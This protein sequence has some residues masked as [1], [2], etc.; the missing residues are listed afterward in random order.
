SVV[1]LVFAVVITPEL[2][3]PDRR[4]RVLTLYFSTAVSRSEYVLGKIIA[5]VL[6]L[7][8]LTLLPLAF[9]YAGNVVFAVHP[10]GY[11]QQH[12]GD[13]L[14]ILAG[15]IVPAVYFAIVGLAVASLTSRRAFAVGGFLALM[16]VPTLVAG[17][18]SDSVQNGHYLRLLALPVS[19]LKVVQGL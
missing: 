9:L 4:D 5:A 3:C 13:I 8:C 17:A 7:L 6:P 18:L 2:L 11:V 16:V 1:I 14:R 19:P 15:G 12:Y 10:A